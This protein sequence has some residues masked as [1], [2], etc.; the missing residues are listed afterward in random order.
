[1][2]E[3]WHRVGELFERGLDVHPA[4]RER[5]VV[6]SAGDAAVA[7]EV[8][9]LL[10][11]ND[12]AGDFLEAPAFR[13]VDDTRPPYVLATGDV[14]AGR[15]EVTGV[16]GRG[17]MGEVYEAHDRALGERVAMKVVRPDVGPHELMADRLR[18]E[19][20]LARRISHPGVCRVHDVAFDTADG[21]NRLIILTMELLEGETLAA[22]LAHGPLDPA[23][24]MSIA[25]QLADALDAAHAVHVLHRDLKPENIFVVRR[26]DGRTRAVLT[27]FGLAGVLQDGQSEPDGR[28]AASFGTPEYMA[29]EL[30]AGAAPSIQSDLYAFALVLRE[31]ATGRRRG[32]AHGDA[33]LPPAWQSAIARGLDPD[34]SVR[35]GGARELVAALATPAPDSPARGRHVV[36]TIGVV[37]AVVALLL[38]FFRIYQQQ[39]AL[40]EGALVHV[41]EAE[42][43]TSDE[44]LDGI[45]EVLRSQLALSSHFTIVPAARV[46]S[47]LQAMRWDETQPLTAEMAR[48]VALREGATVVIHSAVESN[49]TRYRLEVVVEHVGSRP[50]LVRRTWRRAFDADDKASLFLASHDAAM[51]TRTISG[52]AATTLAEQDRP[53]QDTT[54]S[55]WEA[56]RLFG[57]ANRLQ[58][59]GRSSDA[60]LLL[61]DALRFDPEFAAA[62]MRR[63]DI[64]LGLKHEREGYQSWR[65]A[66]EISER[67]QLSSREQLKIR[68]QYLEDTGDFASAAA[69]Y[70]SILVHYPNDADAA[71]RLASTLGFLGKYEEA[72]HWLERARALN[73]AWFVPVVH[74]ATAYLDAGRESDASACIEWLRQSGLIEWAA[75]LE[76]LARWARADVDGALAVLA[77]LEESQDPVWR[78]RLPVLRAAWLMERGDADAAIQSLRAGLTV[79]LSHGLDAPLADKWLHLSAI[80]LRQ[81][82]IPGAIDAAERGLA[83]AKRPQHLTL[84][85]TVFARSGQPHRAR[86]LLPALELEADI[87]RVAA[88]VDRLKG[89]IALAEGRRA[90]AVRFLEQSRMK[91]PQSRTRLHLAAALRGHGDVERAA[92]ILKDEVARLVLPYRSPEPAHLGVWAETVNLYAEILTRS[93]PHAAAALHA[94]LA[95]MRQR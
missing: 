70:R 52:E 38:V 57:K 81:G 37:V 59:S 29:P 78:S 33:P 20:Q 41:T 76:S 45:T 83:V 90:E 32:G 62:H 80:H 95:H 74:L 94:R 9:R 27:D 50:S 55:S 68:A 77:P 34:P 86:A 22:R 25:A 75:W 53:P 79:D 71:F 47:A 10:K 73:P 15:F 65:R 4:D 31:M 64:L 49:G 18:Q 3:H 43:R 66:V 5:F 84:A 46:R 63:A 44:T 72:L 1:M 12:E 14:V 19:V 11:L 85:G 35:F 67:R 60:V 6:D 87:P 17:G 23:A 91:E 26:A 7:R 36:T 13:L 42:N 21:G 16:L 89:E 92:A 61:D 69:A 8:L 24:A 82:D 40:A 48:E 51:W 56:L 88:A 58:L 93:D 54:T 39:P 30:L 28:A 2:R